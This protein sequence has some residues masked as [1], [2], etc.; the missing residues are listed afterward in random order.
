MTATEIISQ[1]RRAVVTRCPH[2]SC[3]PSSSFQLPL[4]RRTH[5]SLNGFGADIV[6]RSD[7]PPQASRQG[8]TDRS[9]ERSAQKNAALRRTQLTLRRSTEPAPRCRLRL[10]HLLQ[11]AASHLVYL[12]S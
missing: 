5:N 11:G 7:V 4:C 6:G 10:L 1:L 12:T 2:T 8:G 3:L 9:E